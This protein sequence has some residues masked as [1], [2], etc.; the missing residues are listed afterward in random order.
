MG[1]VRVPPLHRSCGLES[2]LLWY[3]PRGTGLGL[4]TLQGDL[5]NGGFSAC[6]GSR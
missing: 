2:S 5:G 3:R 1:G 4:L 6:T